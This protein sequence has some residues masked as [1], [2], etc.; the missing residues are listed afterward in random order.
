M[1]SAMVQPAKTGATYQD[2]L[3]A[4]EGFLAELVDGELFLQARPAKP[5]TRV[6]TRLGMLLGGPFDLGRGGPGGWIFMD[7]PEVHLGGAVLVPDMAGWR[8][9][10]H[11]ELDLQGNFFSEAPT[12]LCEITSPSTASFDRVRK[13]PVYAAH[14]VEWVW[15]IDPV[16]RFLEVLH[17]E[18][19]RWAAP[20]TFGPEGSVEPP[21]FAAVP[22]NLS[23]LW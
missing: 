14:G 15:L 7:E 6:A 13:L 4:P 19:G 21:P 5:H 18:G 23:E 12:W 8:R 16:A 3:D 1:V 10:D 9:A 22:L 11:P 17:L 2:V 20:A